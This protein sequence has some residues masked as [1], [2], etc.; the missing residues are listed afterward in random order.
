MTWIWGLIVA[1]ATTVEPTRRDFLYITTAAVGAVG[2]GSVAWPLIS[3]M[4]P[5][6]STL[7]LASTEVDL[8]A[9]PEGGIMTVKWRG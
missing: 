7:A 6:A 5:D 3:Q 9:L 4:N 2:A 1:E 8:A